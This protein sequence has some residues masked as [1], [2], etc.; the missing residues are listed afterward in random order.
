MGNVPNSCGLAR[1]HVNASPADVW[2]WGDQVAR[3]SYS[4]DWIDNLSCAADRAPAA[5]LSRQAAEAGRNAD[6]PAAVVGVRD[7]HEAAAR[8]A[9]RRSTRRASGRGPTGWAGPNADGCV[10]G[11]G[12]TPARLVLPS[13]IARPAEPGTELVIASARWSSS[14]NTRLPSYCGR[15]AWSTQ[16]P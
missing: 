16:R 9:V 14:G 11:C 15:P 3:C 4:Y 2:P 7:R 1:S 12:P 6:R 13:V 8:S 10:V 5:R